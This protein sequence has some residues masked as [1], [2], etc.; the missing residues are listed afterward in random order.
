MSLRSNRCQRWRDFPQ[1]SEYVSDTA[2]N[3]T[4][5]PF[6]RRTPRAQAAYP[7]HQRETP[8]R[9]SRPPPASARARREHR[10]ALPR[11]TPHRSLLQAGNALLGARGCVTALS[12]SRMSRFLLA[13]GVCGHLYQYTKPPVPSAQ[14]GPSPSFVAQCW[15]AVLQHPGL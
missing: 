1:V 5:A 2:A 12:N 4:T 13:I 7:D 6:P 10:H 9:S 11:K 3:T 14:H 8:Q 15:N